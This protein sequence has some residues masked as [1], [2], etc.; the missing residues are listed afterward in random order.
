MAST[1][2]RNRYRHLHAGRRHQ[3]GQRLGL[4]GESFNALDASAG[5]YGKP[6][7]NLGDRDFATHLYRTERL[8]AGDS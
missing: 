5:Y 2:R 7:F 8:R 4:E 3:R 1:S 6:W